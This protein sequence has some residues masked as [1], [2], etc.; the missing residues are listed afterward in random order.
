M[1]KNF[2]FVYFDIKN[3]IG[4]NKNKS[5]IDSS[6]FVIGKVKIIGDKVVFYQHETD[7]KENESLIFEVDLNH[8]VYV[9]VIPDKHKK[10]TDIDKIPKEIFF[11][12]LKDAEWSTIKPGW[13]LPTN[14]INDI[15]NKLRESRKITETQQ[16]ELTQGQ[17]REKQIQSNLVYI[18][19]KTQ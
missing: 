8:S 2:F 3:L 5:E 12:T 18:K 1:L 9:K 16:T 4:Q 14:Y 6:S 11:F 13:R 17:I 10:Y 7:K 19:K 15:Q